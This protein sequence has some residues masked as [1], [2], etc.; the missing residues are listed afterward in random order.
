MNY[1]FQGEDTEKNTVLED[2]DEA[3]RFFIQLYGHSCGIGF[4]YRT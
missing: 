1:G 2:E 3:N 4:Y